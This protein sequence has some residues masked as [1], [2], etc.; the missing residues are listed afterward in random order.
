MYGSAFGR[1]GIFAGG[2]AVGQTLD[3]PIDADTLF[4]NHKGKYKKR[5]EKKRRRLLGQINDLA[6]ILKPGEKIRGIYAAV[7]PVTVPEQLLTG[8]IVYYLKRCIFVVTTHS[9]RP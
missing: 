3:A 4:A 6:P 7:S 8:W 2:A 9:T 5:L 1:H